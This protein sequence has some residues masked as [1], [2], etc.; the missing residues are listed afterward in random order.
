MIQDLT[1]K[2]RFCILLSNLKTKN[3]KVMTKTEIRQWQKAYGYEDIQDQ[4]ISGEI[5]MFEGAAGRMAMSLLNVGVC[6][7]PDVETFDAYGNH[8]PSRNDLKAGTKGTLENS[9]RYWSAIE[10]GDIEILE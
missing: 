5:W 6:Y 7:L 2:V 10:C 1:F 3:K 8:I 9:I 4:I